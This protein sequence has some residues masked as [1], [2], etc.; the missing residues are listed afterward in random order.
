MASERLEGMADRDLMNID[1]TQLQVLMDAAGYTQKQQE[2]TKSRRRRLQNRNSAKISASRR[3][4]KFDSVSKTNERLRQELE[5]VRN[6]TAVLERQRDEARLT[7]SRLAEDNVSLRRE[8][9][10]LTSMTSIFGGLPDQPR[11]F[12]DGT[13]DQFEAAAGAA[14]ALLPDVG[15]LNMPGSGGVA[16]SSSLS[17]PGMPLPAP[18]ATTSR[19]SGG[20]RSATGGG[21]G[22]ARSGSGGGGSSGG[23]LGFGGGY[24]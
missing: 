2:E 1:L 4:S 3:Q 9:Q 17:A 18:F 7:A 8:I 19:A 6:E 24:G 13:S 15:L 12:S 16:Y 11:P 10:S 5:R 22:N 14:A 23:S 21:N 20:H